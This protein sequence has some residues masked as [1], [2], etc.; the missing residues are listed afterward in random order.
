[1]NRAPITQRP[2]KKE[3]TFGKRLTPLK[4]KK[5]S[6]PM[7]PEA[8]GELVADVFLRDGRCVAIDHTD[9]MC[10]GPTQAH[11]VVPQRVLKAHFPPGHQAFSMISNVVVT[12]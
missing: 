10:D 3:S 12:L 1:V 7:K 6:R 5:Q 9:T 2:P 8:M 11:H 4:K